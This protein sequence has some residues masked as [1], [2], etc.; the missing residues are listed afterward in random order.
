MLYLKIILFVCTREAALR[1]RIYC[2]G[3]RN[4]YFWCCWVLLLSVPGELLCSMW[5]LDTKGGCALRAPVGES[6]RGKTRRVSPSYFHRLF[7]IVI[8]GRG[9]IAVCHDRPPGRSEDPRTDVALYEYWCCICPPTQER[10]SMRTIIERA[11]YCTLS[12]H[13]ELQRIMNLPATR[14]TITSNTSTRTPNGNQATT[15]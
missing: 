7:R 8:E 5:R 10:N 2:C 9:V 12:W 1:Y 4:L 14:V 11:N 3:L 6:Y 15:S 13:V